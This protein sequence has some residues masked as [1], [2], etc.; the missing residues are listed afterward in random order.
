MSVPTTLEDVTALV[1]DAQSQTLAALK[2]A[3]ESSLKAVKVAVEAIPTVPT[4]DVVGKLPTP[5]EFIESSFAFAGKVL[6]LEKSYAV[7]LTQLLTDGA[8]KLAPK[9]PASN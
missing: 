9:S 7:K 5:V 8:E 6:D 2:Q 4:I 1:S 3:Q